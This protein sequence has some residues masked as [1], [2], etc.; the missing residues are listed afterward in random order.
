MIYRI[1]AG[2]KVNDDTL[3]FDVIE[4]V[5]PGGHYVT[6]D[7]TI[8][9]MMD[10]F[11]YPELG[12]RCNLD[13]WEERER[14]SMLSRAYER[15]QKILEEGSEGLLDADLIFEIKKAFPGIQNV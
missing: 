11:F 1:L 3:G 8:E 12:V 15:V 6:E 4:Q 9:H 10:E 7:H 5:G 14:P 2:I 13:I